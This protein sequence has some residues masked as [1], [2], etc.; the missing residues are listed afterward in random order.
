MAVHYIMKN[1]IIILKIQGYKVKFNTK[2]KH[3][4]VDARKQ[5][6]TK[7]QADELGERIGRYLEAEG[8]TD[9]KSDEW[10]F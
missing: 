6:L 1:D 10:K 8:F 7:D 4:E 9:D 2:T 5:P 3:A